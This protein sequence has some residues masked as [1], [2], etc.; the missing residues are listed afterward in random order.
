MLEKF[1]EHFLMIEMDFCFNS[2]CPND[3]ISNLDRMED[4]SLTNQSEKSN[5]NQK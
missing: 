4:S 1:D 5:I 2:I 3:L